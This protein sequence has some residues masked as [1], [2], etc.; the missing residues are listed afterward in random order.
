MNELFNKPSFHSFLFL[1]SRQGNDP[2][3]KSFYTPFKEVLSSIVTDF[4]PAGLNIGTEFV[5]LSMRVGEGG[6]TQITVHNFKISTTKRSYVPLGASLAR[7]VKDS[8]I[9]SL[10][11]ILKILSI[12]NEN[13]NV[14]II[15][16]AAYQRREESNLSTL[17][18]NNNNNNSNSN[19]NN[20]NRRRR[21]D[22]WDY[23]N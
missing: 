23:E 3:K 8:L 1:H 20:N 10:S 7:A 5:L 22:S 6:K 2:N 16:T 14:S 11:W 9:S 19:N 4:L 18:N 17:L 13:K 21:K 15:P 12:A